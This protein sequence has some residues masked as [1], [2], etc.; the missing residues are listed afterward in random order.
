MNGLQRNSSETLHIDAY[1]RIRNGA[2]EHVREHPRRQ[3][4]WAVRPRDQQ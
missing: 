4:R 1:Y 3:R 2:I